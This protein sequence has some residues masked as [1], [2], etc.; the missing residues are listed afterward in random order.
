MNSKSMTERTTSLFSM[1]GRVAIVTGG[2]KGIGRA[3]AMA[4]AEAGAAVAIAAREPGSLEDA[5]KDVSVYGHGVLGVPADVTSGADLRRLVDATVDRFGP[6][7][8]LVNNVGGSRG[9]GFQNLPLE[10][11][12]DASFD[13]SFRYNV[14]SQLLACQL[15]APMMKERGSGSIINVASI[16]GRPYVMPLS[17][18]AVYSMAKASV[19]QL[20][21]SM[22]IEWGPEIRV[23]CIAPGLV[24]TQAGLSRTTESQRDAS[25][26]RMVLGRFGRADDFA[27]AAVFLAS[28]ASSWITG[29]VL[30]VNGG[31]GLTPVYKKSLDLT[32]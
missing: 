4:L 21:I 27:G 13:N 28:D 17:Y 32:S 24:M 22:A 5:V 15:V 11:I 30:D 16:S 20:T 8:T 10:Q 2:S 23:N 31:A 3:M 19:I 9:P 6:V 25:L 1:E 18:G 12:D 26:R 7:D 14:K 29:Q